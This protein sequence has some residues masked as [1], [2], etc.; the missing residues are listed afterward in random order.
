MTIANEVY[1]TIHV[2][3]DNASEISSQSPVARTEEVEAEHYT[4]SSF[5]LPGGG[6]IIGTGVGAV[7][8]VQILQLDPL[9]K[10]AVLSFVGTGQVAL[11]HTLNV[12][13]SIANNPN[14]GA[15]DEGAL[16]SS[17]GSTAVE[18]T[19]PLWAVNV[20]QTASSNS[21]TGTGIATSAAAGQVIAATPN[22]PATQ[23]YT[24]NWSIVDSGTLGAGDAQNMGLYVNGVLVATAVNGVNAG[25]IE[26]QPPVTVSV[27]VGT[28]IQVK[29]I[30]N[31]T[32]SSVYQ[33]SV[34]ATVVNAVQASGVI[35]VG[36]V[37]E[38]RNR[39]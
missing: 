39:T 1:D 11:A 30:N 25:T 34:S 20:S 16:F 19:G 21:L 18:A 14:V 17:P 32:A 9:R 10:R 13:Q 27:P 8:P 22:A 38:R 31:A 29:A 15:G 7:E 26:A 3:V 2:H 23:L 36:V 4:T 35:V 6:A 12:A 37:Q 28:S 24:I 33:A 5:S